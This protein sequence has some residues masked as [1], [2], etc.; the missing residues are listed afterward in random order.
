MDNIN[1]LRK[2]WEAEEKIAH[3]IEWEFSGFSVEKCMDGLLRMQE[4]IDKT[5]AVEGTIHRYLIVAKK[6]R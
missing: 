1:E 2:E 6:Q 3:I 4:V 5:G